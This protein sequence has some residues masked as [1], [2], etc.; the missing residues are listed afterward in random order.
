MPSRN[1]GKLKVT[2]G[3]IPDVSGSSTNG[4]KAIG[5]TDD[6]PAAKAGMKNGDVIVSINGKP[7]TNINDYMERLSEL[8]PD[9]TATVV[10]VRN[11]EKVTLTVNL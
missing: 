11:N 6:K 8:K 10:V 7:V 3:I 2:L 9:T 4:L 1:N 5:V